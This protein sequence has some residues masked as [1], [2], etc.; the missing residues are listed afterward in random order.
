MNEFDTSDVSRNKRAVFPDSF[1]KNCPECGDPQAGFYLSE[2]GAAPN[3][4]R[5]SVFVLLKNQRPNG[6]GYRNAMIQACLR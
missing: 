6:D 1:G 4:Y 2:G 3:V 5:G